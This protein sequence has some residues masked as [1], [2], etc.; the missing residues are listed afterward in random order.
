MIRKEIKDDNELYLYFNGKLIYKRWLDQGYSKV[1]DLTA[2]GKDTFLSITTDEDGNV[3]PRRR[4]F[5]NVESCKN[6]RDFWDKYAAEV[7]TESIKHFGKNLEAFRDA[8]T[9]GGPGY[10]GDCII[11]IIG[12]KKLEQIFGKKD[13]DSIINLLREADFV[14]LILEKNEK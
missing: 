14:E 6:K 4:L 12:T 5:L 8:I 10:P 7:A 13:F 2:Y 11:E 1:F 9:A 3:R